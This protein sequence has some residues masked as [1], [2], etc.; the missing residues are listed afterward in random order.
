MKIHQELLNLRDQERRITSKILDK[1]QL[2]QDC[3]GYLKMGYS[4]LFDY[5]VRGLK[6]SE[7]TAYQRQTCV[8][9]TVEVPEIKEK[10]DE[11]SLSVSSLSM[12][13]KHIKDKPTEDKRDVLKKIENKSTR[14]AK[15]LFTEPMKPI[16]IKKTEYKDKVY[17]RLELTHEENKKLE[18][19][20]ALKSH[21][22]NVESLILNLID[23]ELSSFENTNFKPTK[24]KNPRAISKRLRNHAL[25]KADYQ[26][27]YP[28][29][30]STHL[31][32]IDHIIPVRAGGD[33]SHDNLQ[34]LC[35]SHNQ[36]KG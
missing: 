2:L 12:V 7:T 28:G 22:H 19:L 23:K 9:L 15:K 6:Y 26:C 33:Q 17:L 11:G 36:M 31:L 16:K 14:E 4:S 27:Q 32:Q 24:S 29:C 10:I 20:K 21:K 3:K 35:A 30:E 18:K 5:L 25:K 34:V 1:L 13:Y 8:R